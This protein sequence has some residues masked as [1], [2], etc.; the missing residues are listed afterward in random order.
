MRQSCSTP[1][2]F[3]VLD[4]YI[5]KLGSTVWYPIKG[6]ISAWLFRFY[7]S[8]PWSCPCSDV[9]E[10]YQKEM[11]KLAAR[12]MWLIIYSLGLDKEDVSWAGAAGDFA[13]TMAG[14]QLN[15]YPACPNPDKAM[16]MAEHTDSSL[17]TILHQSSTTGLQ[18]RNDS[19]GKW[20]SVPPV[21]GAFVVNVGDLLHVVSN[22]RCRSALHRAVV[23][24]KRHRLSV[25]YLWGPPPHVQ[26]GPFQKLVGPGKQPMYRPVTWPEYLS[27]KATH[28]NKALSQIRQPN[29]PN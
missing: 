5:F 6:F 16:G 9:V 22:G 1:Q 18:V 27:I 3:V 7:V 28:F 19:S 10:E 14:L 15:S 20:V 11:K 13:G 26:L 2:Q 4:I 25:A 24:R 17:L 21:A 12:L 8:Y 23:Q 29:K